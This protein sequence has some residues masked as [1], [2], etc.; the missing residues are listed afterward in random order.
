[1]GTWLQCSDWDTL[2]DCSVLT[3]CSGLA[4][5]YL[6]SD[7]VYKFMIVSY[8]E[9]RS[10]CTSI[11]VVRCQTKHKIQQKDN[12]VLILWKLPQFYCLFTTVKK[13]HL[14]RNVEVWI[15]NKCFDSVQEIWSIYL[16]Y[17]SS[18][19]LLQSNNGVHIRRT[20]NSNL[21]IGLSRSSLCLCVG[22]VMK[23]QFVQ[24]KTPPLAPD[25]RDGWQHP[26]NPECRKSSDWKFVDG[27]MG[28]FDNFPYNHS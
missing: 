6:Q 19:L 17:T 3:S 28:D 23:W 26:H 4:V 27:W 10:P 11:F 20:G 16:Y 1:M 14:Q 2:T 25:I 15:R 9:R 18:L 21:S 7:P 12:D 8:F 24:G 22:P 5:G 13:S